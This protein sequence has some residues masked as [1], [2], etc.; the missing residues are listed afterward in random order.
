MFD[1]W[2]LN[3]NASLYIAIS[4]Y[5]TAEKYDVLG[6]GIFNWYLQNDVKK[7]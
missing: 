7:I 1:I 5:F 2:C 3:K 4:I 6:Y